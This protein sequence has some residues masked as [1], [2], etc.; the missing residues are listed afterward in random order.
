MLNAKPVVATNAYTGKKV[1]LPGLK[2]SA[3]RGQQ[4]AQTVVEAGPLPMVT[5]S[6]FVCTS[7]GCSAMACYGYE[8]SN[9]QP[10]KCCAHR[11]EGMVPMV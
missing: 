11:L 8:N 4:V 1:V 10:N 9:A 3:F 5:N 7:D 6:A 2:R